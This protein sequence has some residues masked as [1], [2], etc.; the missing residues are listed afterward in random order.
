M[1]ERIKTH[2]VP[3]ENYESSQNK[4]NGLEYDLKC[5]EQVAEYEHNEAV[6]LQNKLERIKKWTEIE[7]KGEGNAEEN[8]F[9]FGLISGIIQSQDDIKKIICSAEELGKILK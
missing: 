2:C 3:R 9:S 7:V 6:C 1:M 4:I 5:A 8:N